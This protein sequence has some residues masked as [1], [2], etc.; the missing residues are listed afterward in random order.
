MKHLYVIRV[1]WSQTD[2]SRIGVWADSVDEAYKK[3]KQRYPGAFYY[4][5]SAI[6][7]KIIE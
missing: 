4:S 2:H 6:C 3:V 7:D 1:E 5:V